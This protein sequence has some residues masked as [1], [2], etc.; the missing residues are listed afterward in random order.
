M[1]VGRSRSVK[2]GRT[3][4]KISIFYNLEMGLALTSLILLPYWYIKSSST[5][6]PIVDRTNVMNLSRMCASPKLKLLDYERFRFLF[7]WA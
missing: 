4:H 7:T 6:L 3:I 2:V 1:K 5:N